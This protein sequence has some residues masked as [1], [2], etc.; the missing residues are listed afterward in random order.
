MMDCIVHPSSA[1]V[2]ILPS[3]RRRRRV[4]TGRFGERGVPDGIEVD[5]DCG[6]LPVHPVANVPLTDLMTCGQLGQ[7]CRKPTDAEYSAAHWKNHHALI[8]L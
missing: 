2:L 6:V 7:P 8:L 1:D 5:S 3:G 4:M